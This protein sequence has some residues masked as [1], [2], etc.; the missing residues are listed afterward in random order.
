VPLFVAFGVTALT[1]FHDTSVYLDQVY[2]EKKLGR[3][4]QAKALADLVTGSGY[5]FLLIVL[6]IEIDRPLYFAITLLILLG[7]GEL[8]ILATWSVSHRMLEIERSFLL[9]S[10]GAIV[11][12]TAS[13]VPLDL[14]A[15]SSTRDSALK[16]IVLVATVARTSLQ[17]VMS[18]EA[19]FPPD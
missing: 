7:M 9:T 15:S 1:F 14:V 5:L 8:R 10:A 16:G 4:R 19:Y 12:I 3:M 13:I 6:S 11:A 18:F 2:L 17:Y